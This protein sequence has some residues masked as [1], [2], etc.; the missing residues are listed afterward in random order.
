MI[1]ELAAI[2]CLAMRG[3]IFFIYI[4]FAALI[5]MSIYGCYRFCVMVMWLR[6]KG[7]NNEAGINSS[8]DMQDSPVV[9]V[10]LPL[11]NEPTVAKR[12]IDHVCR[13]EWPEDRLE[14]QVLDDSTDTTVKIVDEAVDYWKGAGKDIKVVR[15]HDRK[16]YKAGALAFGMKE[17]RGD[18]LAVFDAD[19]CPQPGFL[20]AAVPCFINDDIGFV[21]AKWGY[22]NE[23][24]SWFTRLQALFLTGHFVIEQAFRAK[25]GL[26]FNFNGTAG[27]WRR[28]TIVSSGGWQSDTV[29]EDLDLSFRAHLKGWK[30][31]YLNDLVVPSELPSTISAFRTQQRRWAKGSIQTARKLLLPLWRSGATLAQKVDGSV[32][33]LANLGWLWGLIIFITLFPVLISRTGI[34]IYHI[35]RIDL[36]LFISSSVTMAIF[37][38]VAEKKGRGKSL[39]ETVKLILFLPAFSLGIAPAIATG[40]MEGL[41]SRGG[42]FVR[43]P[44]LGDKILGSGKKNIA[45]KPSFPWITFNALMFCYSLAPM[46]FAIHRSTW[47]AMPFLSIFT[48]G[49]LMALYLDIRHAV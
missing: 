23:D 42:E 19:F 4:H 29:T 12:L 32:H 17:A 16:G 25:K 28:E 20:K 43:T 36:P 14:I 30:A 9:T 5:F 35:L 38:L 10:Q 49:A 37:F 47:A 6:G 22:L 31:C 13:I 8:S 46:F 7:R 27:I 3:D 15:R 18:L 33:M 41:L 21:Q 39:N 1:F 11:Y 45:V 40:V 26:F 2:L 34:G 44:K 48:A 24:E